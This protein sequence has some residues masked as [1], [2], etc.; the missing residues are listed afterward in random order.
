[1]MTT[2]GA[3]SVIEAKIMTMAILICRLPKSMGGRLCT[4]FRGLI[5]WKDIGGKG[6]LAE[7]GGFS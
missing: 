2:L 3:R 5:S 6:T 4:A 7:C 1:M